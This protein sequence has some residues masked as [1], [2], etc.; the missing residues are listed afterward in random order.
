MVIEHELP[1]HSFRI[2]QTV[3]TNQSINKQKQREEYKSHG[4]GANVISPLPGL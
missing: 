4:R 2:N 3:L 1:V